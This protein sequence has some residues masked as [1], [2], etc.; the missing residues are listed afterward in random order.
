MKL[1]NQPK[2]GEG[3]LVANY[4]KL[5][6]IGGVFIA[7]LWLQKVLHPILAYTVVFGLCLAKTVRHY[8]K[9]RCYN[10]LGD[11]IANFIGFAMWLAY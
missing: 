6:H 5:L 2:Y 8:R 9:D 10:P 3:L 4:D 11:W 7:I 1:L